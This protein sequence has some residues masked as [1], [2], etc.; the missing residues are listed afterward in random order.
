MTEREG[1]RFSVTCRCGAEL[2]STKYLAPDVDTAVSLFNSEH[3]ICRSMSGFEK[4]VHDLELITGM[5]EGRPVTVTP[6]KY[7]KHG[8]AL[9]DYC[10]PC[11]RIHGADS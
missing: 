1:Y 10:E 4:R 3:A 2:R 6:I 9:T 5:I 7:C 11:G 8:K